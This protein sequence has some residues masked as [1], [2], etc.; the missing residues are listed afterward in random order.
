MSTGY[1]AMNCAVGVK[2]KIYEIDFHEA[3]ADTPR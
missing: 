3:A 1:R 2:M